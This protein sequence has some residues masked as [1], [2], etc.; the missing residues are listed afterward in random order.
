MAMPTMPPRRIF[1]FPHHRLH[2]VDVPCDNQDPD[3]PCMVC[4]GSLALCV[5]CGGAEGSLPTH[6]PG[7][8][9]QPEVADDV[10]SEL[11]DYDAREGWVQR[12]SRMWGVVR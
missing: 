5:T 12:I 3:R 6:C 7:E 2:G 9:M 4:E 8:P 10:Y 1:S 11:L